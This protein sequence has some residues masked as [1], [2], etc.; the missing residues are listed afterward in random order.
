MLVDL[1]I[2]DDQR[3]LDA[4][5]LGARQRARDQHTTA[6]ETRRDRVA[7]L[8]RVEVLA[9][10]QPLAGDALVDRVV[11]LQPCGLQPFEHVVALL[12]GLAGR[13]S[14][15]TTL[16]VAIAAAQASG[17][18]PVVVVWKNGSSMNVCQTFGLA[19]NAPMGITP[20]PS[21]FAEVMM[22]GTTPQ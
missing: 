14:S 18:P 1:V 17:L 8:C 9:D 15:S 3:R 21:A 7:Q 12:G 4:H 6:E 19:M 16:I 10:E 2:L 22:S 11:A 20:P 13:S 5:R